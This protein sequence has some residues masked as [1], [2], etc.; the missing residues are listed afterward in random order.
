VHS[1]PVME[2]GELIG[3][4]THTDVLTWAAEKLA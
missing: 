3:I 2:R 1:L 4:I